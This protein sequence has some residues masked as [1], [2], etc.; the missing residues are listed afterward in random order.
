MAPLSLAGLATRSLS[1]RSWDL[2]AQ[3]WQLFFAEYSERLPYAELVQQLGGA[4]LR[5]AMEGWV[6]SRV[7]WTAFGERLEF[8]RLDARQVRAAF[9]A[10]AE[11]N[12]QAIEDFYQA[13]QP[14]ARQ[15][16]QAFSGMPGR[17]LFVGLLLRWQPS[18]LESLRQALFVSIDTQTQLDSGMPEPSRFRLKAGSHALIRKGTE[19]K[20]WGDQADLLVAQTHALAEALQAL[21]DTVD[22]RTCAV[23]NQM[24]WCCSQGLADALDQIMARGH[25]TDFTG[26]E[27]T[28]W[29]LMAGAAAAAFH[30]RLDQK[31]THVLID[32]F[33]D[34]NPV[35]WGL[36]R[37]WLEQYVQ[38]DDLLRHQA[39]KVFLVG[40]PKQ[41][42]Y[43]FRRADPEVFQIAG[44]W[45]SEHYGAQVLP[46]NTTRRCGPEVVAF[47]NA[48]MPEADQDGRYQP[49]D[50]LAT[51]RTGFVARLPV[52]ADWAAEGHAIAQA[53]LDVRRRFPEIPWSEMRILVRGRRHMAAY[54]QALAARGIP[55]ISD[56]SGGLLQAPE[57]RDLIALLRFL[58]FPWSD[59]DCAHALKSPIFGLTDAVLAA[60][61]AVVMTPE[62]PASFYEKLGA[63]AK[64]SAAGAELLPIYQQLGRWIDWASE[65]PVHDL[66]DRMLHEQNIFERV[67]MRFAQGRGLQCIA[68]L[69]A[70]VMLALELDTGRLP[71]LPRFLQE[72]HRWAAVKDIDAPGPGQM[73]AVNAVA[74]STIHSAK[75]LEADVVVL[76]GL[77]DREKSDSG[78]RWLI[79]WTAARDGISDVAAWQKG[80]PLSASMTHA[81][82]DDRRQRTAEAFNLLYVGATRAR[83]IL[84]LS[85]AQVDKNIDDKWFG[86]MSA[87]AEAFIPSSS[88]EAQAKDP[89][90]HWRGK[91]FDEALGRPVPR[92]AAESLAIRQGKALHRLLEFGP[93]S[94]E[95]QSLRLMAPFALPRAA[96]R[97]VTEA[98]K[99]IAQTAVAEIIF[100]PAHLAYSECEWPAADGRMLRPD[101]LVRVSLA[102]EVWW[103]VDFKWQVLDSE[104][105]SYAKQIAVYRD[106]FQSLRPDATVEA[107]ILTA[108]AEVWVLRQADGLVASLERLH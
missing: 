97:A 55:F 38:A 107:R 29:N 95:A 33:Q 28:A 61:T 8:N 9:R 53:L 68:N 7:E 20:Q 45:L 75:G 48:A 6:Q 35:Q 14:R 58:A 98:V 56:R 88:E 90:L 59:V 25:E 30:E 37:H 43:R 17:D 94:S 51:D 36:L 102:P 71:S 26:L 2:M 65:L 101:R 70:F 104:R 92:P 46:T 11:A 50:T 49:H 96:Q 67:A 77:L 3:A 47:L 93:E 4:T 54:E 10:A 5:Q 106:L 84:L 27:R 78:I 79:D 32:E 19:L 13:Q 89:V 80:E 105:A 18:E 74:L 82:R 40:D 23:R 16:A 108:A 42:I 100:N 57:V 24:L 64:G 72:L 69:E 34:T 85:A 81:L 87:H 99:I 62:R 63:Y 21:L 52:G 91:R 76:A 39:P 22:Q 103:V 73:P 83:R 41:S 15:I 1:T 12:R 31:I 60:I 86:R 44:R 66:L